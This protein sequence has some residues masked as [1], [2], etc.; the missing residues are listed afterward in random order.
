MVKCLVTSFEGGKGYF[1]KRDLPYL[2]VLF[3]RVKREKPV[4]SSFREA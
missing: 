2:L 3:F 1:V 4:K